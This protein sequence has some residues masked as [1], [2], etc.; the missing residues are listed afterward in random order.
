MKWRKGSDGSYRV[1]AYG[2]F[3]TILP[4]R[5]LEGIRS[6]ILLRNGEHLPGFYKTLTSAKR[7]AQVIV[8]N[9]LKRRMRRKK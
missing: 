3:W 4:L 7:G 2:S 1:S 9:L 5:D 8:N 6:Y